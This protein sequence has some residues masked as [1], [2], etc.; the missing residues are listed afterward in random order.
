VEDLFPKK[1]DANERSFMLQKSGILDK[2][3]DSYKRVLNLNR[4]E[5]NSS[6]SADEA[7]E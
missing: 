7:E 1:Y 4:Y 6:M 2:S 3:G 5:E